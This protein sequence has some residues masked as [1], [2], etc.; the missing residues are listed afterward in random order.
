MENIYRFNINKQNAARYIVAC[1]KLGIKPEND[2]LHHMEWVVK[3]SRKIRTR[4]VVNGWHTMLNDAPDPMASVRHE[5]KVK[6]INAVLEIG[7]GQYSFDD[8]DTIFNRYRNAISAYYAQNDSGDE[9]ASWWI[10]KVVINDMF[11]KKMEHVWRE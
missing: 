4:E 10:A 6:F 7:N 11:Y 3:Q 5:D 9:M 2:L 1:K 8:A